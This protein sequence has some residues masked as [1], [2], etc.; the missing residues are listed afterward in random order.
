[1]TEERPSGGYGTHLLVSGA[2]VLVM[3]AVSGYAWTQIPA[4][5]AVCT[6]WNAAGVCD[7]WGSRF[8]GL[9]LMPIVVAAV[10]G[11]F[12]II[13][14]IDPRAA[15][16]AASRTAYTVVWLAMLGFFLAF[17]VTLMLDVLGRPVPIAMLLPVLTGALFVAIGSVMGRV[18]SNYFF[19]IR[20]PWTLASEQSWVKTHRLG[21][22]LFIAEGV[23]IAAGALLR[24]GTLW[25]TLLLGSVVVMLV[26]VTVYS[27]VVWRG[28]PERDVEPETKGND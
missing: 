20:T 27:Y 12:A 24:P 11:L 16:I 25:V 2:V 17:H 1:M 19:G 22:W 15:H 26:V 3:V 8:T 14:R 21:G 5:T 9:F 10:V 4:G 23:L 13:P 18:R 28:D 6:H 7:G